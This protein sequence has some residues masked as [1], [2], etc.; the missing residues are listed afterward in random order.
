[1]QKEQFTKSI[2]TDIL[3]EVIKKLR[4][5]FLLCRVCKS[6]INNT[7]KILTCNS[8]FEI[9]HLDCFKINQKKIGHYK[10]INIL[11]QFVRKLISLTN[12][13]IMIAV[14]DHLKK[15]KNKVKTLILV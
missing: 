12:T 11:S 1:M 6:P 9:F 4:T 13:L 15:I 7:Q 14:V 2:S 5:N 3:V 8:C 10:C